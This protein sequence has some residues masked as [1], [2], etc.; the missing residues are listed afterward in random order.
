MHA[1][2]AGERD[3]L[4]EDHVGEQV[5]RRAAVFLGKSDA[6]Q[7]RSRGLA[8]ELARKF[9]RLV[10]GGGVRRDLAR[11]EA[12]H[13]LAQRLVLGG[14]RRMR[15]HARLQLDQQL[16]GRDLR[17]GRHVHR[18]DARRLRHAQRML[19]LHRFEHDQRAPGLGRVAGLAR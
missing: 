5:G 12:A 7:A 9:L 17:A 13:G 19:H 18:L 8:V 1:A 3:L 10:P 6:E 15:L 11:H 14:E 16:P 4:G 2:D